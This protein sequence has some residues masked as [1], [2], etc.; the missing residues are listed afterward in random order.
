[1][2]R[3]VRLGSERMAQ[4]MMQAPRM[5][6][7]LTGIAA[8][9]YQ[10][11]K[12][13]GISASPSA[14]RAIMRPAAPKNRLYLLSQ[15]IVQQTWTRKENHISGLLNRSLQVIGGGG[16][17]HVVTYGVGGGIGCISDPL[18][19]VRHRS[20][21]AGK[22]GEH[23]GQHNV[24]LPILASDQQ[25]EIVSQILAQPADFG[26]K[27]AAQPADFGAKILNVFAE[28]LTQTTQFA[29]HVLR[30]LFKNR[31]ARFEIW[32]IWIS[33]LQSSS[34]CSWSGA[35]PGVRALAGPAF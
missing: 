35:G 12:T 31:D 26:A 32:D 16:V 17:S 10:A 24:K 9:V 13:T 21:H 19:A 20:E 33:H 2:T 18:K 28:I 29:H 1:M 7:M 5:M 8:S 3:R 4:K 30:D 15:P 23:D 34:D 14:A 11:K 25:P 6:A 22:A 27:F